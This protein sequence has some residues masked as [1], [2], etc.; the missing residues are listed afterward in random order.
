M[1]PEEMEREAL[2]QLG[3][4]EEAFKRARL[5]T[6]GLAFILSTLSPSNE[7]RRLGDV[8]CITNDLLALSETRIAEFFANLDQQ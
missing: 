5:E 7:A 3:H 6:E 8:L 4:I 2:N 1:T